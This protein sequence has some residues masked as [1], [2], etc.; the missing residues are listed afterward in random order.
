M[1][2][3]QNKPVAWFIAAPL[4][5]SGPSLQKWD[6]RYG[7]N[8][9]MYLINIA[10]MPDYRGHN[11]GSYL[12]QE[13]IFAS[14]DNGYE[15]IT[16]HTNNKRFGDSCEKRYRFR[17]MGKAPMEGSIMTYYTKHIMGDKKND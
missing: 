4:E 15:R 13:L 3:F 11:I 16:F 17:K 14:W 10:V 8:N 5:N 7:S 6:W 1:M 2:T 12:M 9:T